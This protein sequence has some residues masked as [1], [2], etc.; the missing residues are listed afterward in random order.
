MIYPWALLEGVWFPSMQ[1]KLATLHKHTRHANA[2]SIHSSVILCMWRLKE[3]AQGN[4]NLFTMRQ[5]QFSV[6]LQ[7]KI[8]SEQ[9]QHHLCPYAEVC[10][11]ESTQFYRWVS[12][13]HAWHWIHPCNCCSCSSLFM[14]VFH[15]VVVFTYMPYLYVLVSRIAKTEARLWC[16]QMTPLSTI[17][18]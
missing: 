4:A 2:T 5:K 17:L 6:L 7:M 18:T 1:P 3:T 11:K 12:C 9:F 15:I 16:M 10:S 14:V 13:W 8:R